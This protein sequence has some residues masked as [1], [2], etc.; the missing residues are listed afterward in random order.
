MKKYGLKEW[1]RAAGIRAVKTMAQT[2]V[3]MLP[4]AATITAVDWKTVVG[5]AALAGVA[6]ILTSIKGLPE[7]DTK[8]DA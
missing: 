8:T 5:T 1:A 7:L 3:A 2:A 4:A 6:S